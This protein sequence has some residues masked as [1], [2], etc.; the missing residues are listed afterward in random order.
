MRRRRLLQA[1]LALAI[2]ALLA[3]AV[4]G[5][6]TARP[7]TPDRAYELEQRLRCPVCKSVSIAESPSET[8]EAMRAVVADQVAAGRSDQE[9]IDYFR[10]RYGDWVLL[11]PPASGSTLALWMLPVAAVVIGGA[12]L[13]LLRRRPPQDESL[14]SE[15][16][17]QVR[18][19]VEQARSRVDDEVTP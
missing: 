12:V 9:I 1:G 16:R 19:A 11:D 4:V 10:A 13:V 2:V 14:T 3:V 8:A 6:L 5:L 17:D 18:R 15:E 7:G